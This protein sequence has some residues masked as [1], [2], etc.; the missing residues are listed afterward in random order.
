MSESALFPEEVEAQRMPIQTPQAPTPMTLIQ[1]AMQNGANMDALER[2]IKLQ[3]MVMARDAEMAFN[4]ALNRC[5][6][7][8]TRISADASNPQTKSRYA[9]YAAIDR[10]LRPIYTAEGFS[11]SFDTHEA[12]GE[13]LLIVAILS[14]K[15]GYSRTYQIPMPNDGKGAKGGDVMT[16]THAQGAAVS[17]GRRYLLSSIFNVAVGED[18]T[19][20]NRPKPGKVT[21]ADSTLKLHLSTMELAGNLAD[22]QDAF[23]KAYEDAKKIEDQAA[24]AK[25]IATKDARKKMLGGSK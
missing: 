10:A 5:Q 8:M 22:L 15:D 12:E 18:D 6:S 16:R 13:N 9:T 21:M 23:Q 1:M 14:H 7:Q 25:I 11:L 24:A 20:G 17:Y 2:L 4:Q 19:D 3:E